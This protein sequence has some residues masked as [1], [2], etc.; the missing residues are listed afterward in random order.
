M[1]K[2]VRKKCQ[3]HGVSLSEIEKLYLGRVSILSKLSYPGTEIRF[4]VIGR[5]LIGRHIFVAFG[6]RSFLP[7]RAA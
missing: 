1:G 2:D 5:S 6:G 3:R 4:L 7:R